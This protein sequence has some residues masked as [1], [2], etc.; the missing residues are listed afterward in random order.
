MADFLNFLIML[1]ELTSFLF[2]L[3]PAF[4]FLPGLCRVRVRC[5]GDFFLM[6]SFFFSLRLLSVLLGMILGADELVI[7]ML[8]VVSVGNG[9]IVDTA[10]VDADGRICL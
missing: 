9:I 4:G 7:P 1:A 3:Q 6:H 10:L 5:K 2:F 8:R